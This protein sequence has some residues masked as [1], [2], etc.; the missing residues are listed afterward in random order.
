[1]RNELLIAAIVHWNLGICFKKTF[2]FTEK[3]PN[4]NITHK[5]QHIYIYTHTH[6]Q[7]LPLLLR[8]FQENQ[9]YK[10]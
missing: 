4:P 2:S 5:T 10:R 8:Q 6:E 7:I 3:P 9:D 1:V